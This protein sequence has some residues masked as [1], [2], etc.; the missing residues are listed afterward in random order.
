MVQNNNL[1]V[2]Q[3]L[4]YC[5]DNM[6]TRSDPQEHTV[7][8]PST[9]LSS[10]Q[11]GATEMLHKDG[12]VRDRPAESILGISRNPF[13][14][15]PHH[16]SCQEYSTAAILPKSPCYVVMGFS[17]TW[18]LHTYIH[19]YAPPPLLQ[20]PFLHSYSCNSLGWSMCYTIIP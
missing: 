2:K 18:L 15:D 13:W 6:F 16:P 3:A 5:S 20:V 9:A 7:P 8:S 4:T 14:W 19:I 17:N 1:H 11:H 12:G 10:L